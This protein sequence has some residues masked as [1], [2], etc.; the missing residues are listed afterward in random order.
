M[1]LPQFADGGTATNVESSCEYIEQTATEGRQWVVFLLEGGL[2][3]V[4][5]NPHIKN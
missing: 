1:E 4:L 3:E 5:T 2:R